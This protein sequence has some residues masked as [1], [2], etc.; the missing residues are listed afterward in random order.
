MKPWAWSFIIPGKY[1]YSTSTNHSRQNALWLIGRLVDYEGPA[2]K[3]IFIFLL[4]CSLIAQIYLK[5]LQ[6]KI[7][8]TLS[9]FKLR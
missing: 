5:E 9:P 1:D 6:A 4:E 8:K 7:K 3:I 2:L